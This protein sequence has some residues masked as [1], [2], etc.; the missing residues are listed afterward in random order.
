VVTIEEHYRSCGLGE[1]LSHLLLTR[2]VFPQF[3]TCLHAAGYPSGRYGSQRW[4]QEE[5]GLAGHALRS[6][7]IRS[8]MAEERPQ[9]LAQSSPATNMRERRLG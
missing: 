4:H 8:S 7:C 2:A 6:T 3:F 9:R 5:S 1:A